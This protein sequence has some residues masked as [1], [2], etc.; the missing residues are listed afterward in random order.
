MVQQ[1]FNAQRRELTAISTRIFSSSSGGQLT[2][3]RS[4]E[5]RA[6]D[7]TEN[8]NTSD[9]DLHTAGRSSP[10]I[11]TPSK[12]RH[13]KTGSMKLKLPYS[14]LSQ[15][16]ELSV[17][18]ANQG[19]D[20]N[21]RSYTIRPRDAPIFQAIRHGDLSQVCDLLHSGTAS[22]WDRDPGGWGV[23]HFAANSCKHH[24]SKVLEYLVQSG[25]D[26]YDVDSMGKPPYYQFHHSFLPLDEESDVRLTAGYKVFTSHRDW[27]PSYP[28]AHLPIEN[29]KFTSD[30][31][32]TFPLFRSPPEET[33]RSLLHEMWPP[34]KDMLPADRI[35]TLF[36][37]F[38]SSIPVMSLSSLRACLSR[39]DIQKIFADWDTREKVELMRYAFTAL[40]ERSA[41]GLEK[42]MEATRLFLSDMHMTGD[43]M[44][45]SS[46]VPLLDFVQHYVSGLCFRP[47]PLIIAKDIGDIQEGL[48]CYISELMLLGIN[49]ATII[50]VERKVAAM[51][52]EKGILR[53]GIWYRDQWCR[54]MAIT[55]GPKADDWR[56]WLSNPRDEW[57][58]EFWDMIDHPERAMPGA[59]EEDSSEDDF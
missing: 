5:T 24:G 42:E 57:A 39:E 40:A 27:M 55:Y 19:W 10:P 56:I 18:K 46:F 30:V 50:D 21:L 23:L 12:P 37:N 1:N 35:K 43:L 49:M 4:R 7:G 14:L 48:N 58:G 44:K 11:Q 32:A 3:K 8:P 9:E 47:R 6:I 13:R 16:W 29:G 54:V 33:I 36:P 31:F 22:I 25:A 52:V 38:G 28:R 20:F 41:F 2:G 53:R 15:V 34:W 45:M 17:Y 26:I 59:W 51:H